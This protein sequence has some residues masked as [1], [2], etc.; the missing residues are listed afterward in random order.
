MASV[1]EWTDLTASAESV[2]EFVR[3][4]GHIDRWHPAVARSER[5]GAIRSCVLSDGSNMEEVIFEHS[6]DKRSYAFD[7]TQGLGPYRSYRGRL[8]VSEQGGF[9]RVELETEFQPADAGDESELIARMT[10]MQREALESLRD[11]LDRSV[12]VSQHGDTSA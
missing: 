8:T 4:P 2:W 3:E 11:Q 5:E 9:V 6:D 7:V 10:K 12:D 1:R